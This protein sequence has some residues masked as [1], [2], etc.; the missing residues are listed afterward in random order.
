MAKW[1]FRSSVF[2]LAAAT[3]LGLSACGGA[4]KSV[5]GG[6]T[7]AK[8]A[9]GT[10]AG[11]AGAG[12]E[13]P[14]YVPP[15]N[16]TEASL[17][18]AEFANVEGL[19]TVYF[20][21]DSSALKDAALDALKKNAQYLKE[22]KGSEALVAGYCDERGTIE[23]NLALGQR[24]AKE[25]REYYMKLGVPGESIATISYGKENQACG[26][27]TEDCWAKNRRAES[28]IRARTAQTAPEAPKGQ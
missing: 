13:G 18:G 2:I 17:R 20:E 26:E 24:R 9:A 10:E 11:K 22:H 21:Y 7:G 16:V 15:V 4:G 27:S 12:P 14:G 19:G 8:G 25:V 6:P 1:N 3:G 5:K 28:R 23:Y